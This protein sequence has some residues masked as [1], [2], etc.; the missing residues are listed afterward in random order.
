MVQYITSIPRSELKDIVVEGE[1]MVSGTYDNLLL[2]A[3]TPEG[4]K[5]GGLTLTKLMIDA[6]LSKKYKAEPTYR[7]NRT[8]IMKS[9]A[10][11]LIRC[12]NA[13][14]ILFKIGRASKLVRRLSKYKTSLPLDNEILIISTLVVPDPVS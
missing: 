10:L 7:I 12:R 4:G 5:W 13:N 2:T 11:Y 14:K 8:P 6:H 1:T 3:Q 9:S